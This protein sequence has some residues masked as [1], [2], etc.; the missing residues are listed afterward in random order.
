MGPSGPIETLSKNRLNHLIEL[1]FT[2]IIQHF[3][4]IG[5]NGILRQSP[6]DQRFER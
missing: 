6:E 2:A 4:K 1:I 3:L 5:K